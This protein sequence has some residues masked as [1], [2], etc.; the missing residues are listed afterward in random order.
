MNRSNSFMEYNTILSILVTGGPEGDL[1]P[2]QLLSA[3]I[4]DNITSARIEAVSP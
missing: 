4:R 3:E 1:L 2:L